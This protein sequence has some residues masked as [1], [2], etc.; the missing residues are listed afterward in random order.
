[1]ASARRRR[2]GAHGAVKCAANGQCVAQCTAHAIEESIAARDE[3]AT[4][5]ASRADKK[6][7]EHMSFAASSECRGR[8]SECSMADGDD[9]IE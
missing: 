9:E 1:M 3:S 2:G 6:G 4:A 7:R 8:A 5:R